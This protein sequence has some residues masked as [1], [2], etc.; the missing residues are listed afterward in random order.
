[1]SSFYPQYMLTKYYVTIK[2]NK[3]IVLMNS[4]L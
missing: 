1:M 2:S 3:N 4:L